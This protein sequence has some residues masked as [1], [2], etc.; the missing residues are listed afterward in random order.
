V[1]GSKVTVNGPR[2]RGLQAFLTANPGGDFLMVI[3]THSDYLTG[4]LVHGEHKDGYSMVAPIDEV[5]ILPFL[6]FIR[7]LTHVPR[8]PP[9]TR[10]HHCVPHSRTERQSKVSSSSRVE[11]RPPMRI[12]WQR[13]SLMSIGTSATANGCSHIL[14]VICTIIQWALQLCPLIYGT[15]DPPKDRCPNPSRIPPPRLH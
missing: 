5:R 4:G 11:R 8:S 1:G 2:I 10:M 9:N 13:S 14:R 12:I 3:D 15:F 7:C 6:I